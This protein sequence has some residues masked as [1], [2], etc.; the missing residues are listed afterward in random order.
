MG[1]DR[2]TVSRILNHREGGITR[3][4]DRFSYDQP[5]RA[6]LE[7]WGAKLQGIVSDEPAAENVVALER[8]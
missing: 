4:Y 3:V 8:A 6:A 5:K 2:L 7:A 1:I